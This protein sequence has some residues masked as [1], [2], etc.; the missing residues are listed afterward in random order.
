MNESLD[1]IYERLLVLRCQ[2]GDEGA[3]AE[4][5]ERYQPRLMLY[6]R[7]MLGD[8][9]AAEDAVQEVWLSVYRAVAKLKD[10][11]AFRGWVYRIARDHAY[12]MLRRKGRI[13]CP[14]EEADSALAPPDPEFDDEDRRL[15]QASVNRLPHEQREVLLLRF[16]E[17]MSYE[18]IA[19]AIGCQLGTVRSRLFYAKRALREATER[20][21]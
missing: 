11:G 4:L 19:A 16:I 3:L 12:S 9:H 14:V 20:K 6:M 15:V 1:L 7:Q 5:I 10:A 13:E 21:Q 17:Q 2:A 18:Q 8:R